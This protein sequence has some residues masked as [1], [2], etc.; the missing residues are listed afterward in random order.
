MAT[1]SQW[2]KILWVCD[3]CGHWHGASYNTWDPT[4]STDRPL[5][6]IKGYG[7]DSKSSCGRPLRPIEVWSVSALGRHLLGIGADEPGS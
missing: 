7:R 1:A 4:N 5:C 3:N 2:P 6:K